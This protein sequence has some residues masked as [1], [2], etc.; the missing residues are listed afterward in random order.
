MASRPSTELRLIFF[1]FIILCGLGVL[2]TKLWWE[3]VA[4]GQM[5]SKKIAGRSEG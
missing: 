3:Q 1:G 2:V 5:W 4:R